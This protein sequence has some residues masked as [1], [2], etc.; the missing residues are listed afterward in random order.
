MPYEWTNDTQGAPESSG[1][2]SVSAAGAQVTLTLTPHRSL[3]PRGFVWF[4]AVTS[5]L[6]GLPMLAVIG[7]TVLWGILPFAALAIAGMWAALKLSWRRGEICETLTISPDRAEL[8]R[9][10]RQGQRRWQSNP[11]WVRVRLYPTGGPV[12]NYLTLKG[13]GREV[14]IGAFLSEAERVALSDELSRAFQRAA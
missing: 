9:I 1:A 4:I 8:L 3:P 14:E 6:M 2:F 10:D 13:D 12:P 11:Y 5:A 7:S